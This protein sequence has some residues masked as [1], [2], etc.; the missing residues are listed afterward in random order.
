MSFNWNNPWLVGIFAGFLGAI[1]I[2]IARYYLFGRRERRRFI[3]ILESSLNNA[4]QLLEKN[5]GKEALNI[6]IEMLKKVSKKRE[7]VLYGNI[8]DKEGIC[9]CKLAY[10]SNKE[11]NLNKAIRA[12]EEALKISTIEQYP[13]DY[14]GTQNN[15]GNAY[16]RLSEVGNKKD[17]LTKAIKA[18][19]DALNIFTVE[20]YPNDYK[21]TISNIDLA[22]KRMRK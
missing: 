4:E 16:F 21:L 11:D 13:V 9:Y 2:E 12:H 7:P 17:N 8:K 18:Y 5:M 6:Y 3:S 20:K 10:I 22:K 15:L 14:A 1:L 19:E